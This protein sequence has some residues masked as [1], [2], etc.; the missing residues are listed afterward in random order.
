V[1]QPLNPNRF[2]LP[3]LFSVLLAVSGGCGPG[4]GTLTGKVTQEGKPLN[5]GTV[6]AIHPNGT[7]Y[8]AEIRPDGSYTIADIPA[9]TVA[10]G[11][12]NPHPVA[13]YQELLGFAKTDAQ[14]AELKPP[15][16]ETVRSWIGISPNYANPDSSGLT[17]EVKKGTNMKD[18]PLTGAPDPIQPGSKTPPP[19]PRVKGGK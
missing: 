18:L 4:V 6:Q 12:S 17:A 15:T 1:S 13:K 8:T 2:V 7:S 16:P 19:P 3:C 11:V 14:R 10:I 9:G 5:S